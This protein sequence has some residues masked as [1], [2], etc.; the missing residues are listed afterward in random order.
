MTKKILCTLGPASM[1]EKTII[2]L[3]DLGVSLFRINLSHTKI[4]DIPEII[5]YVRNITKVPICL[6]TEGAQIRNG[7]IEGGSVVMRE[8]STVKI[9]GEPINGS[10]VQFSLYP[11]YIVKE[12]EIGDFVSVDFDSVL[13]QVV[14]TDD[15]TATMR[16]LNGGQMGQNKAVTVN[17]PITM[18]PLTEKDRAAIKIGREMGINNFALSF[19][20][21]AKDV[22]LIRKLTGNDAFI[23]SKIEC[24]NGVKNLGEI[25]EKSDAILIDRGDLS[26]EFPIEGIPS[27]QNR[28]IKHCRTNETEVYVA[29]NLL[30]SMI[31][32]ATPTRAEVNDIYTTLASGADGLVLAAETAIGHN[33]IACANMITKMIHSFET[34]HLKE[35]SGIFYDD[36]KS[37]L[38][39]PHGGQLICN[40]KRSE[41][42]G[43]LDGLRKIQVEVMD[44][45]DCEQIA[46]G[47][48][49]PITGFMDRET[50]F[51][52]L[53][54]NRLPNGLIWTMPIILQIPHEKSSI[55]AGDCIALTDC[56]GKIYAT[57]DVTERYQINL[58]SVAQK[59]FGTNCKKHPG[60]AR[61][62]E[63]GG[64]CIA[65]DIIL[66]RQLPSIHRHYQ[67][68]PV[69]SRNL[70]NHKG[71]SKVIG[72]HTRNPAHRVH[73]YIQLSA[74]N[75]SHADGLFISPVIGTKKSGDFQT[76]SIMRSYETLIANGIYPEGKVVLGGFSTYS[77]YCGPREMV[78]TML[79]RKNMGT[80]HFIIGRDHAGVDDFYDPEEGSRFLDSLGDLGIK[81]ITF[82]EIGYSK[83][84]KKFLKNDNSKDIVKISGTDVRE[85]LRNN[86]EL[87]DWFMRV[88]VQDMLRDSIEKGVEVFHQ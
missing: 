6:D 82:E 75:S 60:V 84:Q 80:S 3:A 62:M 8:H 40:V 48:Y 24:L 81:P 43:D 33:P 5:S 15:E 35:N 17:R 39:E 51:S 47:V 86:Q 77:R 9:L 72:F 38:V 78:F 14:S 87:P 57:L 45:M 23:I 34:D 32:A 61:F 19:A 42:I 56:E 21:N 58:E 36:P 52:V 1:N 85:A 4:E 76:N 55:S 13:L 71:W 46:T 64:N 53:E 29:T 73:E 88:E 16:V 44:L 30:E 12:L 63:R 59:W 68:T 37:L 79:C 31:H 26:R 25:A 27:L 2:R 69:N 70:F 20:N 11:E 10:D 65:G 83:V 22:E 66:V 54:S 41:D 67:L 18:P 50:L 28:I 74:L 49:S 7:S